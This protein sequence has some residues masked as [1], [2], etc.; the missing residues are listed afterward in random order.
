MVDAQAAAL[1]TRHGTGPMWLDPEGGTATFV[2]I[3]TTASKERLRF[4]CADEGTLRNFG[5]NGVPSP[6][7]A[8]VSEGEAFDQA[9]GVRV[10]VPNLMRGDHQ[11]ASADRVVNPSGH[12]AITDTVPRSE[13]AL[14][15]WYRLLSAI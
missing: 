13:P 8:F 3:E 6:L 14:L 15:L 12:T 7:V 11:I 9:S 4:Q 1:G 2:E 10:K 5:G